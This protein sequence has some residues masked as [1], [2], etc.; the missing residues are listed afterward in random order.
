MSVVLPG[1]RL[2]PN[3][4]VHMPGQGTYTQHGYIYS[5]LVGEMVLTVECQPVSGT[6]SAPFT[7]T[8]TAPTI[9]LQC[10]MKLFF[11]GYPLTATGLN[12]S[13]ESDGEEYKSK[14]DCTAG[15]CAPQVGLTI[16]FK[17]NFFCKAGYRFLN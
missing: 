4:S 15:M 11:G 10:D 5:S 16:L 8:T 17:S 3:D 14:V 1:V 13:L 2:S 6:T 12:L 7:T 9:K